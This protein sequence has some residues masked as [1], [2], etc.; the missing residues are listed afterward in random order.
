MLKRNRSVMSYLGGKHLNFRFFMLIYMFINMF[1]T[2]NFP[3][4]Y[5]F[6]FRKQNSKSTNQS[7]KSAFQMSSIKI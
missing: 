3:N 7:L 4:F 5:T 1:L 6:G 2:P